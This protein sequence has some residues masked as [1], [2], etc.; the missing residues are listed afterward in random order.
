MDKEN[1]DF[2]NMTPEELHDFR[3]QFNPDEMGAEKEEGVEE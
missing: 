2:E 3:S 1:L